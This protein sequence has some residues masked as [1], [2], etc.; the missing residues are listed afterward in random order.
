MKP[1]LML[2]VRADDEPADAEY[3]A[4]LLR[5]GLDEST[6]V[7]HRLEAE[8]MPDLDLADWSGIIVGGSPFN[9]STPVERKSPVQ[10]RVE[11]ELDEL[12][13]RL[14]EEDFPFL[15]AC[16]GLGLLTRHEGGVVD[17]TYKEEVSYPQVELTAAG[18]EDPLCAG[19]PAAFP[20]FVAHTEAVAVAPPGGVVLASAAT[21]PVQVLRVR[22]NLYATQFHP[23]LD[24]DYL[25]HRLA[26]YAGHGYFDDERLP[27]IQDEVRAQDVSDSWK[28]LSNFVGRYAR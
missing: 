27:Q 11:S 8:P 4:F 25:A 14:L 23:E 22:T 17:G 9:T 19:I 7:R 26:F 15:G 21:C 18:R 20:A 10:L 5:T 12:V 6:L 2:G 24:G 13:S 3:E 1:F 28:V 16:Y